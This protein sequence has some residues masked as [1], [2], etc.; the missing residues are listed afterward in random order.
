MTAA[1]CSGPQSLLTRPHDSGGYRATAFGYTRSCAP[2]RR[3]ASNLFLARNDPGGIRVRLQGFLR[4]GDALEAERIGIA[5]LYVSIAMAYVNIHLYADGARYARRAAEIRGGQSPLHRTRPARHYTSAANA[6][7][8]D[9]GDL[10]MA[11]TTIRRAQRIAENAVYPSETTRFFSRYTVA[12]REGRILGEAD[13]VNLGQPAEAIEVLQKALDM[14]GEAAGKDPHDSASR[15]RV[16][17]SA[18][19]LGKI[20][21]DRDPQRALAVFDLGIQRLGETGSGANARGERAS[22]LAHSSYSL[23]HLHRFA[24]AKARIDEAFY[25]PC[26]RA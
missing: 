9:S 21:R 19:E 7:G 2:A 22:L 20:L 11:L 13:A 24:E 4:A 26:S 3:S 1:P 6:A 14:A 10:E 8:D 15:S 12:L 17:T 16:A 18:R 25:D 5:S 23:R